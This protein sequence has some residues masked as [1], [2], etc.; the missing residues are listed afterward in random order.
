MDLELKTV[1]EEVK[2]RK[3]TDVMVFSDEQERG[4]EGGRKGLSAWS[5]AWKRGCW[6]GL[7]T[8]GGRVGVEGGY[9]S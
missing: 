5:R 8:D 7:M 2:V 6:S 1:N 9:S 4:R 3:S